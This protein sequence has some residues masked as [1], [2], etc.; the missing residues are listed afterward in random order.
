MRIRIK[1]V[2]SVQ[3]P[4]RIR[5]QEAKPMPYVRIRIRILVRLC[6]SQ[7]AWFWHKK[8]LG[9]KA[10]LEGWKSGCL[11]IFINFLAPGSKS[12]SGF[13]R[14]KSMLIHADP[15]SENWL[16]FS[17]KKVS[18]NADIHTLKRALAIELI[19]L[20][21]PKNNVVIAGTGSVQRFY[22]LPQLTQS[23]LS[24]PSSSCICV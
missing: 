12:G 3:I 20:K 2:T 7:N 16:K 24:P 15:G 17:C 11:L 19:Y 9:T 6:L 18:H 23:E 4:I 22:P 14:A 10:N 8:Y 13:R 21:R 1:L 5:I